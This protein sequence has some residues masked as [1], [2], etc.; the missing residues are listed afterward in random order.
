[1]AI[2]R[3][4]FLAGAGAVLAAGLGE[5]AAA[6]LAES[7]AVLLA[8]A[9]RARIATA[10]YSIQF[11]NVS[12][13]ANGFQNLIG[14]RA[15]GVVAGLTVP[16]GSRSSAGVSANAAADS[17]YGQVNASQS[18]VSIG[19]WGYQLYGAAGQQSHQFAIDGRITSGKFFGQLQ[20]QVAKVVGL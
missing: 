17:R 18:A 16:L 12:A 7:E 6:A 19:D 11:G 20:L 5:R 15:G 13:Y 9:Q 2:D 4:T 10:S 3:R 14:S 8:P 1:M